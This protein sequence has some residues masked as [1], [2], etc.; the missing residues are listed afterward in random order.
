[1]RP[2]PQP[3]ALNEDFGVV[4]E[5]CYGFVKQCGMLL[6]DIFSLALHS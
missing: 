4:S 2:E 6:D 5:Q 3:S 1:M